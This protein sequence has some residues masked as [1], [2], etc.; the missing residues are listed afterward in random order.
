[1]QLWCILRRAKRDKRPSRNAAS[2]RSFVPVLDSQRERDL[3][4][5]VDLRKAERNY[6]SSCFPTWKTVTLNNY[7]VLDEL[8]K[9]MVAATGEPQEERDQGV[10]PEDHSTSHLPPK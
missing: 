8:E 3:D 7:V 6:S 2:H 4:A 1:M 5:R 9:S 10:E